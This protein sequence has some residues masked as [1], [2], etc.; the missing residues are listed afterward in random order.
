MRYS[1]GVKR[2]N[3][4]TKKRI[5][6][7]IIA[8]AEKDY[9]A[10]ISRKDNINMTVIEDN[11]KEDIIMRNTEGQAKIRSNRGGLI[12][13]ACAVLVVGGG[14]FAVNHMSGGSD[15]TPGSA[16]TSLTTDAEDSIPEETEA[17]KEEPEEGPDDIEELPDD[18]MGMWRLE[19]SPEMI[20][21]V[22][23][24]DFIGEV[25]VES[26]ARTTIDGVDYIDY[27]CSAKGNGEGNCTIFKD[28]TGMA[29]DQVH[30]MQPAEDGVQAA[31]DGAAV[32]LA[33]KK[34]S[35][36]NDTL[37]MDNSL[38]MYRWDNELNLY[39][40]MSKP[41]HVLDES[42]P[43]DYCEDYENGYMEHDFDDYYK[44]M[45]ANMSN[46]NGIDTI[47]NWCAFNNEK[48]TIFTRDENSGSVYDEAAFGDLTFDVYREATIDEVRKDEN[49][50]VWLIS[51]FYNED[52]LDERFD[53][54]VVEWVKD[55]A[56]TDQGVEYVID[57][58][59]DGENSFDL[60]VHDAGTVTEGFEGYD[61]ELGRLAY[62]PEEGEYVIQINVKNKDG[63]AFVDT[64]E[65]M[66]LIYGD[67]EAMFDYLEADDLTSGISWIDPDDSS[68]MCC[69]FA[70]HFD[71]EK[72][73]QQMEASPEFT[74][75]IN[76]IQYNGENVDGLFKVNF[77]IDA[78]DY[79]YVNGIG[80]QTAE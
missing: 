29:L 69:V 23:S 34:S 46:V 16:G 70:F 32:L 6:D 26:S 22:D 28:T 52:G 55:S 37:V 31:E 56:T 67:V 12:A 4:E 13:A 65:P 19:A 41:G 71:P 14:I 75:E 1:E 78:N 20:A 80:G 76:Q 61:L 18:A 25:I 39:R 58:R 59:A 48:L 51:W 79:F 62:I 21:L 7:E 11:S 10:E 63:S 64:D 72:D 47:N 38:V 49:G 8:A 9:T 30:I 57:D 33:A 45:L 40:I 68:T 43:A 42:V 15:V 3:E 24:S 2:Y 35:F 5:F 77:K 27:L 73:L 54:I 53:G 44:S 66:N 17:P 60:N 74:F 50:L 36:G